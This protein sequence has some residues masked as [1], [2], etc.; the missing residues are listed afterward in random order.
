MLPFSFSG[1]KRSRKRRVAPHS[2]EAMVAYSKMESNRTN[3]LYKVAPDPA[4]LRDRSE[5]A[6]HCS[7]DDPTWQDAFD[8]LVAQVARGEFKESS[9]RA[10]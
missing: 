5:E 1:V 7:G 2:V 8:I 6:K 4:S 9:R 3:W 10:Q